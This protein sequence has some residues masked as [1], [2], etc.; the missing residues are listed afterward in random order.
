[1]SVTINGI[2]L[3]P[4]G[5]LGYFGINLEVIMICLLPTAMAGLLLFASVV[6]WINLIKEASYE[7]IIGDV[8]AISDLD[9]KGYNFVVTYMRDGE[10]YFLTKT[11]RS[12]PNEGQCTVLVNKNGTDIIMSET[13]ITDVVIATFLTVF[14]SLLTYG[15]YLGITT[16]WSFLR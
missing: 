3:S 5:I 4:S 1:M 2:E 9:G 12:R 11:Q 7:R 15:L 14:V 10:K 16:N 6:G 8:S 13:K